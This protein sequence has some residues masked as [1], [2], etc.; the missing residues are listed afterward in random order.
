M[1]GGVTGAAVL[2][3]RIGARMPLPEICERILDVTEGLVTVQDLHETR[4]AYLRANPASNPA[5]VA[6]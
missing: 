4:L 5:E 1:I 2:L 3:W 6:K